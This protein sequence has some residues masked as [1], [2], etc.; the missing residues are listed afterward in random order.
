MHV[1]KYLFP[2]A[3]KQYAAWWG[4]Q[5]CEQIRSQRR[6]NDSLLQQS[7]TYMPSF[8]DL[9]QQETSCC[10]NLQDLLRHLQPRNITPMHSRRVVQY[11]VQNCVRMFSILL[12]VPR[13]VVLSTAQMSNVITK[14]LIFHTTS[15]P[16]CRPLAVRALPSCTLDVDASY[17]G[18]KRQ[19]SER[20]CLGSHCRCII[21]SNLSLCLLLPRLLRRPVLEILGSHHVLVDL[22][23]Q[24]RLGLVVRQ[25]CT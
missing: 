24:L 18:V 9:Q 20:P 8:N 19:L 15:P 17:T 21:V 4:S 22:L 2:V 10:P 7:P 23:A 11:L 13:L 14:H 12:R 16:T 25:L 6:Q 1:S 3:Q 5:S